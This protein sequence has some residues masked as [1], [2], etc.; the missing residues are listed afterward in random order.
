[1]K[2]PLHQALP[3]QIFPSTPKPT[4]TTDRGASATPAQARAD[5]PPPP[6]AACG[7]PAHPSASRPQRKSPAASA[8]ATVAASPRII[9]PPACDRDAGEPRRRG[10]AQRARPDRRQVHAQV[11]PGL[12]R[13]EE[14]AAGAGRVGAE[15]GAGARDEVEQRVGA[16]DRTR[17]RGRRPAP[18]PPPAR[19]P[20]RPAP[21]R[22][23][24]RARRPPGRAAPAPRGSARPAGASRSVRI[25]C[26]ARTVKPSASKIPAIMPQRRV[27]PGP[28]AAQHPRRQPQHREVEAQRPQRRPG[29]AAGEGD[30]RR[31][32]RR[33]GRRT[34]A[35]ASRRRRAAPD[36]RPASR[37]PARR[38]PPPGTAARCRAQS[39]AISRGRS[40]RPA[41]MAR[42]SGIAAQ[43]G[44]VKEREEPAVTN[45]TTSM[46][47]GL[48][49]CRSAARSTRS[50]SVPS[51]SN[52]S[53]KAARSPLMSP[54]PACRALEADEV[55]PGEMRPLARSPS[56]R[57]SRR[58]PP[59]PARRSSRRGRAARTGAPPRA[60]RAP[61]SRRPRNARPA[62]RCWP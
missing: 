18:P 51:P 59:R 46:T 12:R 11:L 9:T 44:T 45:S 57:G 48:P 47:S 28:D 5:A 29:H 50:C 49:A 30:Q 35:R 14:H 25:S 2:Q 43:S 19:R 27:V 33:A 60:R 61:R 20:P 1:M 38:T 41:T 8:A 53:P 13:L 55:Q 21:R 23:A 10:A 31:S 36:A 4:P 22:C 52:I 26:G 15:A 6:A 32:R 24:P 17:A 40:P 58:R 54:R 62:W 16:L 34:A 3:R 56:R 42:P 37:A 39:S 7:R